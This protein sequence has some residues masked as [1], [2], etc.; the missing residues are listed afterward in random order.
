MIL[1][2]YVRRV[3]ADAPDRPEFRSEPINWNKPRIVQTLAW[4]GLPVETASRRMFLESCLHLSH[5]DAS[6]GAQQSFVVR[7][8]FLLIPNGRCDAIKAGENILPGTCF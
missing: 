5:P 6:V 1:P 7:R 8:T 4:S 2:L 3:P